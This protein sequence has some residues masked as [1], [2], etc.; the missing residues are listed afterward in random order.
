MRVQD[1]AADLPIQQDQ[2]TIDR[3]RSSELRKPNPALQ[4]GQ[5]LCVCVRSQW[6]RHA[7]LNFHS[8]TLERRVA[9]ACTTQL[10]KSCFRLRRGFRAAANNAL[11]HESR[12]SF[13]TS[14]T[15][16]TGLLESAS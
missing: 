10:S 14:F 16:I 12:V 13:G 11:S 4:I 6:F 2:F 15:S 8:R 7:S 5:E 9:T 3:Q 1:I